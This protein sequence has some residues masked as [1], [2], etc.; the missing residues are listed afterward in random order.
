MLQKLQNVSDEHLIQRFSSL[1]GMSRGAAG[2]LAERKGIEAISDYV[3]A[4]LSISQQP[5]H[6]RRPDVGIFLSD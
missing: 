4:C 5:F 6:N 2:R 3:E 1:T